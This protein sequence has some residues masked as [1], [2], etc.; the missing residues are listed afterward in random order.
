M[1]LIISPSIII[2]YALTFMLQ[3]INNLKFIIATDTV[4]IPVTKQHEIFLQKIAGCFVKKIFTVKM[5]IATF[6]FLV[7]LSTIIFSYVKNKRLDIK[8]FID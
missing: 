7:S 2:K 4:E 8:G 3:Y 6:N 1:C 5:S